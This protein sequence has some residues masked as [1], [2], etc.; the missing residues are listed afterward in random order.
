MA[1]ELDI[2]RITGKN[3]HPIDKVLDQY[4]WC[5][6]TPSEDMSITPIYY[7]Y[8]RPDAAFLITKH[9][10]DANGKEIMLFY[11]ESAG[12]DPELVL[13]TLRT[14]LEYKNFWEIF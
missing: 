2:D 7:L 8:A 13:D 9:Y 6:K 10:F 4:E 12:R 1:R 5:Q 11:K 3:G 14:E